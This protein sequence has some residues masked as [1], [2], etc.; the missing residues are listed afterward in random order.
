DDLLGIWGDPAVTGKPTWSDL[1]SAKASLPLAAA[2]SGS[3]PAVDELVGLLARAPLDDAGLAQAAALVEAAGG[4]RYAEE[5][6]GSH[7]DVAL[8]AL[9]DADLDPAAGEELVELAGFVVNRA[10]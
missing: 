1:R 6:A 3:G 5:A 10:F 7:L 8:Q 4:R 2:L 9:S